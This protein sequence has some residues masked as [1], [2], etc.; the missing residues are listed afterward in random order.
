MFP[1]NK[2]WK[3]YLI[4]AGISFLTLVVYKVALKPVLTSLL[5]ASLQTYLP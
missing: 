2:E 5:P 1:M 3:G 4:I